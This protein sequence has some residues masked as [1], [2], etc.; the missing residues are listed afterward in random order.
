MLSHLQSA[1]EIINNNKFIFYDK[2]ARFS[3]L[4]WFCYSANKDY[5]EK[6]MYLVFNSLYTDTVFPK[7]YL[8]T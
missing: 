5:I 7:T 8:Y 2:H 3:I 6:K 4:S 1:V